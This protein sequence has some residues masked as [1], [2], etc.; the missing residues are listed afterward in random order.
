MSG[1]R[2]QAET[3]PVRRTAAVRHDFWLLGLALA[4][5]GLGL[6][7]VTSASMSLADSRQGQPLYFLWRQLAHA[8]VGI[9]AGWA[10]YRTPV[11]FWER[12]GGSLLLIGYLLL[13]LV[14]VPGIGREVNGAMRWLNLGV[15]TLQPSELMK[16]LAVI[17]VAGYMVRRRHEVQGE[18]WGFVKPVVLLGFGSVLLLMEPDFGATVVM[19]ATATAMLFLG[20]VRIVPFF[21]AG[22]A[23]A[24][25]ATTLV[26]TSPYRMQRLT[27]FVDPWAD[28]FDSGFQLTQA[29]IAFGRG[30]W[31]G[32]GLGASI[33][34]LSYL[35]EAHTDFII[36]V[37]AE[38]LGMA[39]LL[40]VITLYGLLLLRGFQVGARA[41]R[42]GQAFSAHL[43]YG[44]SIWL[45]LQVFI[46]IGVN[47]GLLPT[48]GLTL[49]L[50]SY[51]GSSLLVTCLALALLLRIAYECEG[52]EFGR[53]LDDVGVRYPAE[54][55]A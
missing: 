23:I 3:R 47:M 55:R 54:V 51:G 45:G 13:A 22:G 4:L 5:L 16:L 25:L 7:M 11:A 33:Q 28:P 34:K 24:G 2:G 53:R 6:V 43:A 48:K 41:E 50:M 19:M 52:P 27:T 15:M 17:F 32:V 38:E 21:L 12:H 10:V 40:I 44:I 20:G 42:A 49:P 36:A 18:L 37:L 26:M 46:S 9:L 8:A 14:L 35:P 30:D 31:F 39:G 29:L 1:W